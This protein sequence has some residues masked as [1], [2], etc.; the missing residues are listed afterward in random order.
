VTP[1]VV[2]RRVDALT[3]AFRATL[4]EAALEEL[5]TRHEVAK[6]HGKAQV[7]IGRLSGE[8]R[9]SRAGSTWNVTGPRLRARVDLKA[10][11]GVDV[12]P[13]VREP[14]WTVE[15]VWS[16]QALA[17]MADVGHAVRQARAIVDSFAQ[18]HEERVRRLDLCADVAGWKVDA[19][20]A[21]HL[22][23]R[24]RCKVVEHG[25]EEE[26]AAVT[27][28]ARRDVTGIS[29]SPGGALMARL[30]D[31]R[32]ELRAAPEREKAEAERWTANG[33]DGEAPITR[34]EFQIRGEGIAEFGA[35]NPRN[36]IEP[37]TGR[38]LGPLEK[39]VDGIWQKCLGW[40][41]LVVPD[42]PRPSRC[43]DDPRWKILRAVTFTAKRPPPPA[44]RKRVRGGATVEQA[45][46]C[47]LSVIAARGCLVERSE[48]R[49]KEDDVWTECEAASEVRRIF[50]HAGSI[51]AESLIVRW[52]GGAGALV[53]LATVSNATRARFEE[54]EWHWEPLG[55]WDPVADV[56]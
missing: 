5:R 18:V 22:V 19:A 45:L 12:L 43:S 3:L 37:E 46:G 48:R 42:S 40:V 20:D 55:V 27:M 16:A 28:H 1:T 6:E 17:E 11:G 53:H 49:P 8:M 35:R 38:H 26:Q 34:V 4:H 10:P 13:G 9:F 56:A 33:W 7:T 32:E 41:R 47:A 25:K 30:Y 36:A 39:I 31:K 2:G 29:V 24:P 52:G 51:V 50:E 54:E 23:R 21:V 14:G 44:Y 15:I